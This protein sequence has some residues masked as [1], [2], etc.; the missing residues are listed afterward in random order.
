MK[1]FYVWFDSGFAF[2]SMR[3]ELFRECKEVGR[4][5]VVR[6]KCE[7]GYCQGR[8]E[9][10]DKEDEGL[11]KKSVIKWGGNFYDGPPKTARFWVWA[12]SGLVRIKIKP[13]QTLDWGTYEKTDEGFSSTYETWEWC[14]IDGLVTHTHG[15]DGR[16]CDGRF[17]SGGEQRC[18]DNQL[19]QG[20]TNYDMLPDGKGKVIHFPNWYDAEQY[21]RDYEAEKAGY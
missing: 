5:R 16:D 18:R 11:I 9:V 21:Q 7:I 12:N 4:Y 2:E 14:D 8:A 10:Y 3:S 20:R 1:T 15:S 13:G 6:T 19:A 17:Q